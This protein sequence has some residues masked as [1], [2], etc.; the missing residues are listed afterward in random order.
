MTGSASL[1]SSAKD[2]LVRMEGI[3]PRVAA[4]SQAAMQECIDR[5]GRLVW[6]LARRWFQDPGE[7]E[8][9]VQEVFLELWRSA[10]RFRAEVAAEQT[11]VAMVA[12]RRLIDRRRRLSRRERYERVEEELPEPTTEPVD[13]ARSEDV[14]AAVSALETL[15]RDQQRVLRLAIYEGLTHREIA[16]RTGLPLGTVKTHARR[17]LIRIRESLEQP[18]ERKEARS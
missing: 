5:Y 1:L 11:F 12:R 18:G 16:T 4:G 8:D 6:G 7:A 3:L 15:S 17:G 9:A 13:P 2:P 10:A 14:A